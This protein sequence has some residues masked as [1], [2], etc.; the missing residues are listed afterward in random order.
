MSGVRP[1]QSQV[2]PTLADYAALFVRCDDCGNGKRMGPDTLAGLVERGI[3]CDG[4]LRPKLVCQPCR[5][6]GRHGR[7]LDLIPTFRRG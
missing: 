2:K 7:N 4:E 5:D 1:A 3:R 6:S